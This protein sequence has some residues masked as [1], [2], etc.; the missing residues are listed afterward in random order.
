M[1]TNSAEKL[2][3]VGG[4][5]LFKKGPEVVKHAAFPVLS[6]HQHSQDLSH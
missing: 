1:V 2:I 6:K 5:R 4:A 3:S